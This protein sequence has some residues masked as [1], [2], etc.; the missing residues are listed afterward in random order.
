MRISSLKYFYEVSE[1]KSISKVS[2]NLHISQPALSHQLSKLEKELGVKL[3]NRSNKG[4]ELTN[5]GQV[6]YNY[7]K[8]ILELHENLIKDIEEDSTKKKEIR[9][10][11]LNTHANFLL[12]RVIKD[13]GDIFKN[14]GISINSQREVNK[15]ALLIHNRADIVVGCTYIDDPDLVSEYIG[16]DKLILVSG[17]Y[18]ECKCIEKLPIAILDDDSGTTLKAI[19]NIKKVNIY[20]KTDSLDV[21]KSYL[22]NANVAAIVPMISVEDELKSGELMRVCGKGYDLSYDLFITYRKD[23]DTNFKKKFKRFKKELESILNR[24]LTKAAV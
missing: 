23:I 16:K 8:Q 19:E 10:N 24:E 7:A 11:V 12:N 4:V 15:K 5:Q 14:I 20:L 17:E 9:I 3:F 1:L 18:L 22:K 13:M 2:N 6:L 21:I